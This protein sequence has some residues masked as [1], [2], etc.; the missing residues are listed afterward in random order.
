MQ[1]GSGWRKVA[2]VDAEGERR[3]LLVALDERALDLRLLRL[4]AQAGREER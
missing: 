4:R 1:R 2:P 3:A